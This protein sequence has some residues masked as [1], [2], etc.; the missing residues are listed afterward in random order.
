VTPTRYYRKKPLQSQA[1]CDRE[2]VKFLVFTDLDGTLLNRGNYDW[3]PAEGALEALTRRGIPLVF[4]TSKTRAEVEFW[5][6]ELGNR[7][8][9]IVENGAAVFIPRGYFPYAIPRTALRP[10]YDVMQFGSP[11]A[12]LIDA[13]ESACAATACRI[14]A[15]YGMSVREIAAVTGLPG[16]QASLAARREYSE[17]FEILTPDPDPLLKAIEG[18][19][20]QCTRGGRFYHITGGGNKGVAVRWLNNLYGKS[21]GPATR[22]GKSRSSSTSPMKIVIWC[23]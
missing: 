12:I 10:G 21:R 14:R 11:R 6:R 1:P 8:P 2:G 19:G 18:R 13:I 3:R 9:F 17:P 15:F 23:S 5:R 16:K 4:C 7:H 22:A 20:L